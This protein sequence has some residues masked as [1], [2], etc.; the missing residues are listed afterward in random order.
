MIS[1][2]TIVGRF[3]DDTAYVKWKFDIRVN[4][5]FENVICCGLSKLYDYWATR[6]T[7]KKIRSHTLSIVTTVFHIF[8]DDFLPHLDASA[9]ASVYKAICF[10]FISS[11]SP[12]VFT[13]YNVS[14]MRCLFVFVSINDQNS[15]FA[16]HPASLWWWQTSQSDAD[17]DFFF[18]FSLLMTTTRKPVIGKKIHAIKFKTSLHEKETETA[19]SV[20]KTM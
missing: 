7:L 18:T 9:S 16:S 3:T 14:R 11:S 4:L 6:E 19:G 13:L 15:W 8:I 5:F 17:L 1:Q 12:Y 2:E 20:G 10:R